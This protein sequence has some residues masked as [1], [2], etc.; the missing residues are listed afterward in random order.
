MTQVNNGPVDTALPNEQP[1]NYTTPALP[2]VSDL[3]DQQ[4]T[5]L[6]DLQGAPNM[7]GFTSNWATPWS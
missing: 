1:L 4:Q 7:G 5:L 2:G 6:S 3:P